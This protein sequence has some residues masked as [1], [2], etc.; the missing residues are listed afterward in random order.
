MPEGVAATLFSA[1]VASETGL[2][3]G[4]Y[5]AARQAEAHGYVLVLAS[6]A[7]GSVRFELKRQSPA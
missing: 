4:L 3:I 2:G 5:H 6:N 1:P 7:P